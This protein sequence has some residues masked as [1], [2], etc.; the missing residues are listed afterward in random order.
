MVVRFD[1]LICILAFFIFLVRG[2][3]VK[4]VDVSELA[5]V[6]VGVGGDP[7]C[8]RE[9]DVGVRFEIDER[10]LEDFGLPSVFWVVER[11]RMLVS[12]PKLRMS[13]SGAFDFE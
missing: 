5:N 11:P 2:G 3:E 1:F 13:E 9:V 8:R 12:L 10:D 4:G 6:C 7:Q